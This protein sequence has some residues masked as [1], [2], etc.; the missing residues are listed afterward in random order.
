MSLLG[1]AVALY[2]GVHIGEVFY[3]YY[4]YRDAM[5]SAA[6]FASTLPDQALRER[7]VT[8]AEELDLPPEARH[9]RIRRVG[10]PNRV[11]ISSQYEEQ[12]DLPFFSHAFTFTPRV[13]APL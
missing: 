6:R 2:Y 12:V 3:R 5:A 11:L 13:E 10:Q 4:Q 7:I 1:F 9:V 8:R